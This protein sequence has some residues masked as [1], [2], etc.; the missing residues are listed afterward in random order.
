M[1]VYGKV[2]PPQCN[3]IYFKRKTKTTDKLI[4]QIQTPSTACTPKPQ[5]IWTELVVAAVK[6]K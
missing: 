2:G 4:P 1:M 5:L 6:K 3:H